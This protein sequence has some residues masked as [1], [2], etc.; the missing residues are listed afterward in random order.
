MGV[1]EK[2]KHLLSMAD[3]TVGEIEH[4]L[5][6][7]QKFSE[8]DAWQPDKQTFVTNLF[9]EP[10]TRTKLSFEVAEKKLGLD[11]L[12]FEAK[13]SSTK[14]GETLYDT[15]KTLES[16]GARA[17]VIRHSEDDYYDELLNNDVSIPIINAG[18]GSG[19]HPTQSLLDLLT[20]KQEFNR[21]VGLTVAIVG[22]IRHS[23]VAH[24]NAD[25]LT[26]L[27]ANVIFSGPKEWQDNLVNFLP[28]DE[29]VRTADVVMMLRIQHERHADKIGWTVNEYHEKHGLTI[30]REKTMKST[31]IIMHPA[32][33]NRGVEIAGELVECE[34]SRIFKQMENGVAVRMAV[35]KHALE[36]K[37]GG[38]SYDFKECTAVS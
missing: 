9:F 14:K 18:A 15:V 2:M 36:D 22:D 8:G 21:F 12:N 27:G 6:D 11:V 28:M 10:S 26:K 20:I 34:R 17:A 30:E 32:P 7:A 3:L 25:A 38:K 13:S 5:K 31:S 1:K 23:R 29:A 4:I 37:K 35:L 24:S 16:I 33:V 19:Q